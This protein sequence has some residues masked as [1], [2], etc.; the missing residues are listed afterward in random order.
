MNDAVILVQPTFVRIDQRGPQAFQLAADDLGRSPLDFRFGHPP[1]AQPHQLVPR[2]LEIQS[3][4]DTDHA[5]FEIL[6]TDLKLFAGGHGDGC[7]LL[8]HGGPLES[9]IVWGQ[10]FE[11]W[12][13]VGRLH[14][15]Q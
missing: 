1:A 7:Q 2:G 13:A 9:H 8:D 3:Q 12:L 10:M 4:F 11:G 15:R 6:D 5:V 14:A